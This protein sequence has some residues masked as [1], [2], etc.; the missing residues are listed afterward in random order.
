M[1]NRRLLRI[2]VLQAYY[3]YTKRGYD[4]I[5]VTEKELLHSIE[6]SFDLFY[7]LLLLVVDIVEYARSRIELAKQKNILTYEDL[8]P[9]TRFIDNWYVKKLQEHTTFM[10]IIDNK[11]I[12]WVNYPELIR[13]LYQSII[14]SG[15]YNDYMGRSESSVNEDK[16]LLITLF[17]NHILVSEDMYQNLE[18]QSIYWNDDVEYVISM[19]LKTISKSSPGKLALFSGEKIFK[20]EEDKEFVLRLLHKVILKHKDYKELIKIYAENWDIE[21][22]ALMDILIMELAIAEMVEFSQ[23]PVRVSLNEYIE[24]S[25]TY[26]SNKSSVFINGIL[27]KITHRLKKEKVIVKRGKGLVGEQ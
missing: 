23:I 14:N 12:S 4:S 1:I 19:I 20:N 21:R 15:D 16:N 27:D 2:K 10:K 17:T 25:K 22:I 26:S 7:Y 9:N 13:N 24:I 8:H 6:K 5:K 18:E 3:A 11:K